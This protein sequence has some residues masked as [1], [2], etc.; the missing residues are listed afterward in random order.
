MCPHLLAVTTHARVAC[1]LC[2][3]EEQ[4]PTTVGD[5]TPLVR[6]SAP[7]DVSWPGKTI[8][9]GSHLGSTLKP[10]GA[11]LTRGVF[12]RSGSVACIR[13]DA[14]PNEVLTR[15]MMHDGYDAVK[16]LDSV[17]EILYAFNRG[18]HSIRPG[19][20]RG[21]RDRGRRASRKRQCRAIADPPGITSRPG[22][23]AGRWCR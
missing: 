18:A 6:A 1:N 7:H 15:P 21:T 8:Q 13:V 10:G 14:S 23:R 19:S 3:A 9:A 17:S 11:V 2:A 4:N 5:R 22:R 20:R 12:G 16:F